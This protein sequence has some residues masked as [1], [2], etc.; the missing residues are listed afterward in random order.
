MSDIIFN[1][2]NLAVNTRITYWGHFL[3]GVYPLPLR[4][5]A[6]RVVKDRVFYVGNTS[7]TSQ[8]QR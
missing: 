7:Y 1:E 2:K 8:M 5:R 6:D 4:F 3:I